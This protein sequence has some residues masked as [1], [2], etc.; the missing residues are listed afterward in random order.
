MSSPA[1]TLGSMVRIPHEAWMSVPVSSVFMFCVGSG[2]ATWLI[3]RSSSLTNF[4][5]DPQFQINCEGNRPEGPIRKVEEEED[6]VVSLIIKWS[7]FQHKV[8]PS[9]HENVNFC[10]KFRLAH[11]TENTEGCYETCSFLSPIRVCIVARNVEPI[12]K[13]WSRDFGCD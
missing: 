9:I 4:L 8:S 5:W 7:M 10:F 11:V 3:T 6:Y 12:C 13:Y 1:L 2:L